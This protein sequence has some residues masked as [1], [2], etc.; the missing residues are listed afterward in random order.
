MINHHRNHMI[1]RKVANDLF[2]SDEHVNDDMKVFWSR[3]LSSMSYPTVSPDCNCTASITCGV[4]EYGLKPCDRMALSTSK[5]ETLNLNF[6]LKAC[7]QHG[8]GPAII[9]DASLV[10]GS[11]TYQLVDIA[12]GALAGGE[13]KQANILTVINSCDEM[14]GGLFNLAAFDLKANSC[15][16]SIV[17]NAAVNNNHTFAPTDRP[18]QL[19]SKPTKKPT[20]R[21]TARVSSTLLSSKPSARSTIKP[22]TS[23]PTSKSSTKPTSKPSVRSTTHPSAK[24]TSKSTLRPTSKPSD[25]ATT[26]RP[27]SKMMTTRPTSHPSN[28]PTRRL[29]RTFAPNQKDIGQLSIVPSGHRSRSPS[30]SRRLPTFAPT[31]SSI[32]PTQSQSMTNA[33]YCME[34]YTHSPH[35]APHKSIKIMPED[36]SKSTKSAKRDSKEPRFI[37][38]K[39]NV[40]SK[41]LKSLLKS[42]D[43]KSTTKSP[44]IK[45]QSMKCQNKKSLKTK[46]FKSKKSGGSRTRMYTLLPSR[47]GETESKTIKSM[48]DSRIPQRHNSTS[49]E[50]KSGKAIS[51]TRSSTQSD[52]RN[53]LEPIS[54]KD[55][56]SAFSIAKTSPPVSRPYSF[57]SKSESPRP[58]KVMK[59]PEISGTS[60]PKQLKKQK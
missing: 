49:V 57:N 14:V 53:S 37:R 44:G 51:S 25:K 46:S 1:H 56:Q 58:L 40:K 60:S 20:A 47:E 5:C 26:N 54:K 10:I 48:R 12:N 50:L 59:I 35:S 38:A 8:L 36:Y 9:R 45:S 23:K 11:K 13:C 7:N 55:S 28:A 42:I 4:V 18:V 34:E 21:H 27:T 43:F 22:T 3:L 19:S 33:P 16:S 39:G 32:A 15:S 52:L 30:S 24:P 2:K 29:K 41:T 17:Y 6:T 31:Q